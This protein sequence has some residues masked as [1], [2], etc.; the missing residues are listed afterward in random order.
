MDVRN[1]KFLYNIYSDGK[2][3]VSIYTETDTEAYNFAR[4]L[5]NILFKLKFIED[6]GE[7]LEDLY[8]DYQDFDWIL[9]VE[10]DIDRK[11]LNILN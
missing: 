7:S 6:E 10:D 8:E 11:N 9:A 3:K 1:T 5:N 4:Q 2:Y